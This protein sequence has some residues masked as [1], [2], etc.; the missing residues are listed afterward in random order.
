MGWQITSAQ[1]TLLRAQIKREKELKTREQ[2]T[3]RRVVEMYAEENG[4]S[5]EDLETVIAS[6]G[7]D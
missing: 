1:D 7:L 3:A 6:L 4:W 5:A 2:L